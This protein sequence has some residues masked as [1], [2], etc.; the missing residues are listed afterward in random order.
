MA[1][2]KK[3]NTKKVEAPKKVEVETKAIE[4]PITETIQEE[5]VVEELE[6][7]N[8]DASVLTPSEEVNTIEEVKIENQIK[9]EKIEKDLKDIPVEEESKKIENKVS[10]VIDRFFG[11]S[12]NGQEMDY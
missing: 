1:N 3:G 11:Y 12:W 9:E 8:G 7:V 4:E 10:R 2:N 6:V 5:D